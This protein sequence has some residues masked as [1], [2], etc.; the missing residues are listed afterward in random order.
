MIMRRMTVSYNGV[1]LCTLQY[2]RRR[3][4]IVRLFNM[5]DGIYDPTC[6]PHFDFMEISEDTIRTRGFIRYKLIQNH[7]HYMAVAAVF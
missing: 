7:C 3:G 1:A 2:R 5:I 4:G 6:V